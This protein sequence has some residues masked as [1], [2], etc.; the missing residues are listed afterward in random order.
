MAVVPVDTNA[1]MH[2]GNRVV[3]SWLAFGLAACSSAPEV[4]FGGT[5]A[6]TMT[7]LIERA[8]QDDVR[9]LWLAMPPV[10]RDDVQSLVHQFAGSVDPELLAMFF[11]GMEAVHAISVDRP[12]DVRFAMNQVRYGRAEYSATQFVQL[13]VAQRVLLRLPRSKEA[14]GRLDVGEWLRG[15]GKELAVALRRYLA[16]IPG[17]ASAQLAG[18]ACEQRS[19]N[20]K[21]SEVQ[22]LDKGKA[23]GPTVAFVLVDGRW[24]PEVLANE[25]SGTMASLR[26]GLDC[27]ADPAVVASAKKGLAAWTEIVQSLRTATAE[28]MLAGVHRL[29]RDDRDDAWREA[30]LQA[31]KSHVRA[32]AECVRLFQKKHDRLP[33][34]SELVVEDENGVSFLSDLP[35]DPWGSPY[36]LQAID[37]RR[38]FVIRSR[39][40]DRSA[41]TA[42]DL[43]NLP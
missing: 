43:T 15:D 8:R 31:A 40:P 3:S 41:G 33:A 26:R 42:D 21:R 16:E 23:I 11:S 14:L 20:A 6:S 30:E 34:L 25:W 9:A 19:G 10:W 29:L 38:G 24:V 27:M 1:R 37:D 2:L 28:G 5:A 12:E 22:F 17:N 4:D 7:V 35:N 32:I 39:G 13:T 18:L 36:E